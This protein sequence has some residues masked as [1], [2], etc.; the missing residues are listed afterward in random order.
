MNNT[1]PSQPAT[2]SNTTQHPPTTAPPAHHITPIAARL[3]EPASWALITRHAQ[4]SDPTLDPDQWFP[5]STNPA[6]ARH[7]AAAAIAICT[8]CPVRSHCLRLSLHHWDIGQHGIWG[9]LI[10]ADRAPLRRHLPTSQVA[11]HKTTITQHDDPA[12]T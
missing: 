9:G 6:Q 5:V 11:R 7:E 4:C 12:T 8:T 2:P 3:T 10:A 1:Q